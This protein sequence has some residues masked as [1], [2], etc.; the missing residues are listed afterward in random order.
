[1]GLGFGGNVLLK[2]S[3]DCSRGTSRNTAQNRLANANKEHDIPA[4]QLATAYKH[5]AEFQKKLPA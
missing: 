3:V 5:I 1:M 2:P 4:N